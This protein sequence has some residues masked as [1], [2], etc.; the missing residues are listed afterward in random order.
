MSYSK[1]GMLLVS[2]AL[3]VGFGSEIAFYRNQAERLVQ[4]R[5]ALAK[6]ADLARKAERQLD[7][8]ATGTAN[9][10]AQGNTNAQAILATLK[11]NGIS[12]NT[13][14]QIASR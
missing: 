7:G 6:Q 8:L 9:L 5:D 1:I 2:I 4:S 14:Q 12:V 13:K 11:S 10:A 3:T